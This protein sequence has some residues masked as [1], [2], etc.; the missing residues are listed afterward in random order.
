MPE[1]DAA[2]LRWYE[3]AQFAPAAKDGV[4]YPSD[5]RFKVKFAM[6]Q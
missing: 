3:T 1:L 5:L 2:A 4:P 6:E